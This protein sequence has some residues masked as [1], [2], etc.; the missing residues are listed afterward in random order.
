MQSGITSPTALKLV[1]VCSRDGDI[2]QNRFG[3][4]IDTL[5]GRVPWL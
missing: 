5:K 1:I 4:Q 2:V 3:L